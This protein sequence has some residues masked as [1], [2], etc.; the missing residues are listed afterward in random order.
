M[1][2]LLLLAL[3]MLALV[4]TAVACTETPDEPGTS[5]ED[6]TTA[7]TPT[8]APDTDEPDTPAPDTDEP[9][10]PA[11]DTDEPET[12]APDTDE[13]DTK[14]PETPTPS[15]PTVTL[16]KTE[17]QIGESIMISATGSDKDW[18]GIAVAGGS[19][20][21]RWWYVADVGEGVAIDA[22]NDSHIHAGTGAATGALP[23]GEYEVVWVAND[24]SLAVADKAYRYK[25]TIKDPSAPVLMLDAEA[26]NTLAGAAS[27]N[28]NH[29]GSTEIITEGSKTF[30]RWTAAGGDPY[31]AI[32]PLGSSATLPQYMAISY[33]T[34]SAVEGQFFVGSGA[35]WTGNGDSFMVTWTEGDWSFVIVDL[36]QTGVTSITD[37]LLTYARMDFFAGDSAEGDYF[38]VQY[39]GFF[40]AAEDAQAYDD[41][42][43]FKVPA[44]TDETIALATGHG[45]PYGSEK[46]F[47][48]RY[49]IG[50]NFLKQITVTDMATYSD[51]NTNKWSVKIWA[52]NTD[53]AA[54]TS[55][56]PLFELTGENHKDNT[57]FVVDVPADLGIM[58]DFYYEV[59]YLEGSAQFTGWTADNVAEGV[60]TYAN[61]NLKDGSYASSIVVGVALPTHYD[62][63]TVPQD[64]WV[65]T[66][67]N[68]QL[69][70][71]SNGMVSAG[72]VESAALLHQGSI[73]LGEID[74]SKYSK[75]VVMWGCDNSDV[76]VG[77]Y[78]ENANNRIMLLNAVMDGVMSPAEETIIAGGTY[79]LKGWAVTAFE[80]DLTDVDYNGPV[81]LA[82]DA[83]PGTF[84]LFAS[85]EF[86]GAEIEYAPVEPE[87]PV[88][89]I[90]VPQDQ[91][92]VSGHCAQIVGKEGHANSPM[93]AAGGIDSGALLHQGAVGIGE[94]D[95]SK[96]SKVIV[97]YGIDGSQVTIDKHAAN[98]TN[99]IMLS[100]AD[101]HMTNAP[102]N[103]N[104][105]AS[106]DYTPSGWA[107]TAIEIDLT[108]VDYNGPVF[109]TW[110]TLAGTFM[111]IGSIEFVA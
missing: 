81:W 76:T 107:L 20:S 77:R 42:V 3:L 63:Y 24:Q 22:L 82:I 67:H 27:P 71:A 111:L 98:G 56:K 105:I 90:A 79:E 43:N 60:E 53:Y 88:E 4:I 102:A 9:E 37:G 73:A 31:V 16:D 41:K 101:N 83:L 2:K 45:A 59:E 110:D 10:T 8:E 72:G 5:A 15:E 36:T 109:I 7:E 44:H 106:V 12:P 55:A 48:Q 93:V 70:D 65:M 58:G 103:E 19:E 28:V 23:A 29:L 66:G 17:Y 100:K 78:N 52:W 64:Q 35:G 92:T 25:F 34:N 30:V 33:R 97:K 49:N 85:V 75:V 38:D 99:R 57:S 89:T 74:L 69:N 94:I 50:E 14:E 18:V 96:Y 80:I 62:N 40:N 54:T 108:A 51:G 13:P 87:T 26:L 39:V 61:G 95:L 68:T 91:W 32:L 11:P 84:A 1:K 47:G 46:K 21:I 86:I 6:V 104:V